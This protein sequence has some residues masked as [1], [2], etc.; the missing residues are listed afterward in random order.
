MSAHAH[1]TQA[2]HY[3]TSENPTCEEINNMPFQIQAK[4]LRSPTE[5]QIQTHYNTLR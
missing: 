4:L 1:H 5:V 3:T 2:K